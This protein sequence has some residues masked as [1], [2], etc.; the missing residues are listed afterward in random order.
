MFKIYL[1][2]LYLV[3]SVLGTFLKRLSYLLLFPILG[4]LADH[5]Y[6]G[7]VNMSS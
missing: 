1:Q 3:L 7:T 5:P 6:A 4:S 2:S